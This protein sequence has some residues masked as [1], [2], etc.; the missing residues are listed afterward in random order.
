MAL[1]GLIFQGLKP[2]YW[3]PYNETAVADSEIIYKDVKDA[4]IYL[5]FQVADGKGILDS[6]DY[7]VIWTTTPWTIPANEAV[8]LNPDLTYAE[9]QTEKGKRIFLESMTEKLLKD[10][11][12][13]RL[14]DMPDLSW[15]KEAENK[16]R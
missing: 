7:F 2:I 1:D 9:V 15:L 5:A 8:S 6:D 12:G 10:L 4:T 14:P 3:S 13:F 11:E 16:L